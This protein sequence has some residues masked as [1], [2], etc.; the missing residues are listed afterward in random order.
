MWKLLSAVIASTLLAASAAA[1][2]SNFVKRIPFA[3]QID[4]WQTIDTRRLVVNISPKKNYLLTL[5]RDCYG[6]KFARHIG[7]STSNNTI[8][9]GFDVVTVDGRHC[10]IDQIQPVTR[11]DIRFLKAEA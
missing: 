2:D 8:Y 4:G 5:R 3:N 6:L 11:E 9:A 10:P 7:V 1:L